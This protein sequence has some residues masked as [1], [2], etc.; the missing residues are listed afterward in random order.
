MSVKLLLRSPD[1]V[2]WFDLREGVSPVGLVR[3]PGDERISTKRGTPLSDGR[4]MRRQRGQSR[5]SSFWRAGDVFLGIMVTGTLKCAVVWFTTHASQGPNS[6]PGTFFRPGSWPRGRARGRPKPGPGP[7][8]GPGETISAF[9]SFSCSFKLFVG[10]RLWR[11]FF[12]LPGCQATRRSRMLCH[13][14]SSG[15]VVK[16]GWTL[17]ATNRNNSL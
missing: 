11:N 14:L 2:V 1:G 4:S 3:P 16:S 7:A 17:T 9:L 13:L 10:K 12:L 8:A 6:P 5:T 15:P